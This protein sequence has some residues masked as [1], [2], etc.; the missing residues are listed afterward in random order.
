MIK[1]RK[2]ET[3]DIESIQEI[4][5]ITWLNTYPNKNVG[6]LI[7]DVEERF[8]D[9][10]SPEKKEKMKMKIL[11][12]SNDFMFMAAENDDGK[13]IGVC[14]LTKD[15]NDN[16]LRSIYILPEFQRM[17]I[18]QLFWYEALNFFDID[19]DIFV[20]VASYNNLAINFYKK[21]GFNETENKTI[22]KT[23]LMPVSKVFIPE[24]QME[25][26]RALN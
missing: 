13:I 1:I 21:L 18:G 7:A 20:K 14:G 8:K 15:K 23:H 9:R 19:K 2:A 5:Y 17:G 25:I 16:Y 6:I 24:I 11:D 22:E 3:S 4:S 10:H 26:K 12:P